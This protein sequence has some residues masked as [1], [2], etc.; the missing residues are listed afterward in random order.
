VGI[1][2]RFG[3]RWVALWAL[4][5]LALGLVSLFLALQI[6]NHSARTRNW[7]GYILSVFVL[8]GLAAIVGLLRRHTPRPVSLAPA[9]VPAAPAAA[10]TE[11]GLA[12]QGSAIAQPTPQGGGAPET[13][14]K[15]GAT[16]AAD[17]TDVV[18]GALIGADGRLST[19]KLQAFQWTFVLAWALLS[20]FIIDWAGDAD[21]YNALIDEG[22]KDEYLVL[23]GGPFVALIS[24]KAIV[25]ALTDSG[26]VVKPAAPDDTP[27][28]ISSRVREAFSDDSG[29]TDL[30]DTQYLI[31][32]SLALIVF[33]VTF[34]RETDGGLPQLPTFLVALAGAGATTYVAKKATLSDSKPTLDHVVPDTVKP[35]PEATV[36]LF[37]QNLWSVSVAGKSREPDPNP[38]KGETAQVLIGQLAAVT[39]ARGAQGVGIVTTR[40]S[41]DRISFPLPVDELLKHASGADATTKILLTKIAWIN[42]LGVAAEQQLDFRIDFSSGRRA[43][44]IR[45][46]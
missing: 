1:T 25:S 4:A 6:H 29:N 20:I 2:K 16:S 3:S 18:Q 31:F 41:Y 9:P 22:I 40:S 27:A 35:T 32:G 11:T 23:L 38:T 15:G 8:L 36:T 17:N 45:R 44:L 26:T 33:I 10:V 19:S 13:Q 21:G 43:G 28:T 12:P 30:V 7:F 34:I 24:A 39:I 37:G 46:A 42:A 5:L 14:P